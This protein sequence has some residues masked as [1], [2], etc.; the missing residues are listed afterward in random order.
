MNVA[1]DEECSLA[2]MSRA[3]RASQSTPKTLVEIRT[4]VVRDM[5]NARYY[6]ST[7]GQF[8]SEDPIFLGSRQNLTDPQSLNAYS[9][10]EDN[11]IIKE[12]PLGKYWDFST[13][14]TISDPF[15]PELP[16]PSI[17]LDFQVDRSG[18]YA[19]NLNGGFGWGAYANL[20]S[21]YHVPGPVTNDNSPTVG[22]DIFLASLSST[23]SNGVYTPQ[24]TGWGFGAGVDVNSRWPL[25]TLRTNVQNQPSQIY[26]GPTT[27]SAY[28]PNG[29]LPTIVNT[30]GV[31]YFRNSSGLLSTT[32]S[33][34]TP[35][36]IQGGN[37]KSGS[38][39]VPSTAGSAGSLL[40]LNVIIPH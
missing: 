34:S 28:N 6:D 39:F 36:V 27:I 9:Y 10:S 25:A 33:A 2:A 29:S 21:A 17:A 22:R 30:G 24:S 18:G 4:S 7:Q 40:Q 1:A 8:I 23:F 37:G 14:F 16:G 5:L 11:P 3:L 19:L 32:M 26:T 31:N 20:I 12:D 35:T 38:S 13:S 15:Q